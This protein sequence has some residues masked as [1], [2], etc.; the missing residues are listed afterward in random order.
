MT[1][2]VVGFHAHFSR[3]LTQYPTPAD[4]VATEIIRALRTGR[5]ADAR[6]Y[7][8]ELP[9]RNAIE[10]ASSDYL[11]ARIFLETGE[12][13]YALTAA[14]KSAAAFLH[15]VIGDS[16]KSEL[17]QLAAAALETQ[18]LL[19]RRQE[20]HRN[21]ARIHQFALE[22]RIA[23]GSNAAQKESM[24]S[25]AVCEEWVDQFA[26]AK[27]WYEKLLNVPSHDAIEVALNCLAL[28]RWSSLETSLGNLEESMGLA[29]RAL[30]LIEADAPGSF[31]ASV[32]SIA[33]AT[34]MIR[35]TESAFLNSPEDCRDVV[36]DTTR[37]LTTLCDELAA[38]GQQ[39]SADL[40]W[41]TDHLQWLNSL[42]SSF[43][44]S[45]ST[46]DRA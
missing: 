22:L 44:P 26:E 10:V 37:F 19:L 25:L 43:E 39:A 3:A 12:F 46:I 32:A 15:L 41:C 9:L 13:A 7:S 27:T 31:M 17:H 21:A 45:N 36:Q 42:A 18:G 8:R 5:I 34:V 4:P 20:Q 35:Q 28:I 38:F 16:S 1:I 33:V 40:A 11:N 23:H 14:R 2:P 6:R 30:Q 24:L 29:R